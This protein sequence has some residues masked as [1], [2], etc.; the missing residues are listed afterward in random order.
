MSVWLSQHPKIF[1]SPVKEP[2][3]FNSAELR[4]VS[5]VSTLDQYEALFC[6]ASEEHMA[7]GEAS[8]LYLSSIESVPAI[9]N[10]QPEAK[11]IVML[12][13]PIDMAPAFHGHMLVRGLEYEWRFSKA[14]DLQDERRQGKHMPSENCFAHRYLLYGDIC[15]LGAQL[16][17]LFMTVPSHKVLTV[18]L[19]DVR[20]DAKR[21]YLRVLKFLEAP[22]DG[23]LDFPLYNSARGFRWATL[24]RLVYPTLELK[25]RL[26]VRTGLRRWVRVDDLMWTERSRKALT[27]AM[28]SVLKE[29]FRK[30]IELLSQLLGRDLKRWLA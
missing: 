15:S 17:R 25:S 9:L 19:D 1:M 5:G 14:W 26:G 24:E 23:R 28:L 27:P 4:A 7:I 13:N 6:S 18:I 16:K 29:Y 21:E 20:A 10:Y 11:F 30:D 8:A 2:N 22:D 12:R 3:F